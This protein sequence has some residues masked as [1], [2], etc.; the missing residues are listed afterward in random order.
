MFTGLVDHC[1]EVLDCVPAKGGLQL[2]IR[3]QFADLAL[4][5]SIAVD[6]ICLTVS[7]LGAHQF[8]CEL[9][10]ETLRLTTASQWQNGTRLNLERALRPMD[11]LG[12]HFVTG[13]IDQVAQLAHREA[14]ADFVMLRFTDIAPAAQ[15]LLVTKGSVA[16]NGVSL[17]INAVNAH[18]FDVM[19][20]P[21]TL[22]HTNLAQ[23]M[24]GR[25]VNLEFDLLAKL[26]ANQLQ[27]I[28]SC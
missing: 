13:H 19:L 24:P 5:E 1:D 22:Q 15:P 11:R 4:G 14:Q 21:H 20:I 27:Q 7:A 26:V 6:G 28:T 10:P 23:L 25:R 2:A 18:G 9:S 8:H 16:V 17:T 12:G 3:T